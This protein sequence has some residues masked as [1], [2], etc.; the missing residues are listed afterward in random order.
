MRYDIFISY[1]RIGTGQKAEHLKDLLEPRYKNRISFDRE[2]LTGLFAT[3]LIQRIDSCKDFILVLAQDS[4]KYDEADFAEEKV[5]LYRYLATCSQEAFKEK[6]H[7]LG[8]NA[9]LDFVRIELARALQR[10]NLNIIPIVPQ[11]TDGFKFSSLNLPPDIVGVK[12]YEALFYSDNA[13]ALF[14]DVVPKLKPHLKSRADIP[15]QGLIYAASLVALILLVGFG[16][17][18]YNEH[19]AEREAEELAQIEAAEKAKLTEQAYAQVQELEID[20]VLNQDISFLDGITVSQLKA[21][22][23]ILQNMIL[24]EGGTFMQGAPRNANGTYNHEVCPELETPQQEKTVETFYIA[25]YEVTVGDWCAIMHWEHAADSCLL[26]MTNISFEECA[27]F[28][29]SLFNLSGLRFAI[30][31][32]SE[33]EYA[34]RGGAAQDTTTFAGGSQADLVAWYAD[35]S[36]DKPHICDA[37]E[38]EINPNS[39][40]LF[41]MSGNICEWCNTPWAPYNPSVVNTNPTAKV[42][43]GGAYDSPAYELAVYHRSPKAPAEKAPNVGLRLVIRKNH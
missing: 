17:Y 28:T 19:K 33:W 34:A 6:I 32:E 37:R 39:L 14:K 24:V 30:P 40:D 7:E 20:K 29:D 15:M 25:Q 5:E 16:I 31:T 35:N 23:N 11:S 1:R 4:F 2:N 27:Q 8:P 41:N 21:I 42:I 3:E 38:Y 10:K 36:Q 9:N 26:P 18:L 43:R 22:N 12:N 13:D